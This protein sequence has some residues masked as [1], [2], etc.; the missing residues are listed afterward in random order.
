[1]PENESQFDPRIGPL[2]DQL[3]ERARKGDAPDLAEY[4]EKYPELA[5]ELRDLYETL[6]LMEGLGEAKS[7]P[8]AVRPPENNSNAPRTLGEFTI[9]RE[10]GRGGMG[11]VYEAV[12][13]SLKRHVAVKVLPH[14]TVLSNEQLQRFQREARAAG[15]LKHKNIVPV[16]EV[17]EENGLHFY[18]MQY[19]DGRPLDN[20]LSQVRLRESTH[21]KKESASP[22]DQPEFSSTVEFHANHDATVKLERN[23]QT[24]PSQIQNKQPTLTDSNSTSQ[25]TSSSHQK[26]F[27]RIAELGADIAHALDYAH[28]EGVLHRDIKPSNLLMDG[29]D[30][31]WITD[32]GLAKAGDDDLTSTGDLVGTLRYM[33]PERL[34]GWSDPRS[35]VYSLGL[36]LYEMATLQPA[37]QSNDRVEL[38]KNLQY[39]EPIRPRKLAPQIP[40]DLETIILKSIAKEPQGRY[41]SSRLLAEDLQRFLDGKPIRAERVTLFK[42]FQLWYRRQPFVA[43]LSGAVLLLLLTVAIVST[44]FAIQMND[45]L[46]EVIDANQAADCRLFDAYLSQAQASRYSSKSGRR[47]QAIE[48]ITKASHL[49]HLA[50]PTQR[51]TLRNEFIACL[52]LDDVQVDIHHPTNITEADGIQVGFDSAITRFADLNE[53]KQVQLIDLQT[54]EALQTFPQVWASAQQLMIRLSPCGTRI[55]LLGV[56]AAGESK[57]YLLDALSGK[58]LFERKHA[59]ETLQP[60][61]FSK[62]GKQ[63]AFCADMDI[64]VVDVLSGKLLYSA[65]T[66]F[67]AQSVEFLNDEHLLVNE[68]IGYQI[69]ASGK[70][71]HE[72]WAPIGQMRATS[73]SPDENH[74]AFSDNDGKIRIAHPESLVTGNVDNWVVHRALGS[75]HYLSTTHLS[76]HP[77]RPYL[78]STGYDAKSRIWDANSGTEIIS[79]DERG[80]QFSASGELIGF[81]NKKD[82]VG[83]L[84]FAA[85]ETCVQLREYN[86]EKMSSI[87]SLAFS[88]DGKYLVTVSQQPNG[89]ALWDLQTGQLLE[90]LEIDE[91]IRSATFDPNDS[92]QLLITK[93]PGNA[94]GPQGG[95][96]V[97]RITQTATQLGSRRHQIKRIK[98]IKPAGFFHDTAFVNAGKSIIVGIDDENDQAWLAT[99][100][101]PELKSV[102][103]ADR[104]YWTEYMSNSQ[105][106]KLIACSGHAI[107]WLTVTDMESGELV[108]HKQNAFDDGSME[109][110]IKSCF[111]HDGNLLAVSESKQITIYSTENWTALGTIPRV[112]QGVGSVSFSPDNQYLA[113]AHLNYVGLY[114][115]TNESFTEVAKLQTAVPQ[116]ISGI[117]LNENPTLIFGPSS[118]YLAV[119][120]TENSTQLWDLKL[121]REK[122]SA[123]DLDW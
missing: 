72:R 86:G 49:L 48:A 106:G 122:L 69:F 61:C 79:I 105:D 8:A 20:V 56:T 117:S 95:I 15:S 40:R 92:S 46:G 120:T 35:D 112:G 64:L 39:D 123:I 52:S 102:N 34:S 26:Y 44:V 13:E 110:G 59:W 14:S 30:Q 53:E 116:Q 63:V 107:N 54:G 23:Q 100:T 31:I 41:A 19:I 24:S 99:W 47:F 38:L 111:S 62:D 115:T 27:R 17:G 65:E 96:E 94:D 36:T 82:G 28:S 16:F 25:F 88:Q 21:A 101:W 9:V 73:A 78:I 5:D 42:R 74:F 37:F 51:Q 85:S 71:L 29:N 7:S 98:S 93:T 89:L 60:L 67:R 104:H 75:G 68:L 43:A 109:T 10:I 12:Q 80:I 4:E 103:S 87:V 90:R 108:M 55:G 11:I 50:S 18:V 6:F 113:V 77:T 97:C 84:Q 119:G 114:T 57:L 121:L 32:F 3:L 70:L 58:V 66:R 1:M 118:R 2:V 76:F 33:P 22:A 91:I 83:R 81:S 45:R